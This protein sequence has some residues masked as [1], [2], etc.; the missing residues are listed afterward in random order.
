MKA[1]CDNC[2]MET[3]VI[4][5]ERD[6]GE[7]FEETFFRC[8]KCNVKYTCFITDEYVRSL[9]KKLERTDD[10]AEVT[11]L[12]NEVNERMKKLKEKHVE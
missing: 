12:R 8:D 10:I 1:T 7:G 5:D 9:H 4:F 11:K 2:G 3:E 6:I